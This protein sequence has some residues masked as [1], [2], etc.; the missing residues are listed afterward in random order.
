MRLCDLPQVTAEASA[1]MK[2]QFPPRAPAVVQRPPGYS[3]SHSVCLPTPHLPTCRRESLWPAP[4]RPG[5]AETLFNFHHLE[6]Q[7]GERRDLGG[8]QLALFPWPRASPPLQNPEAPVN[9]GL[10]LPSS[11]SAFLLPPQLWPH[12]LSKFCGPR[13]GQH[14][15]APQT[16][17]SHS[18]VSPWPVF[19]IL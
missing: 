16:H 7:A 5:F 13:L 10:P 14:I 3:P 4:P 12:F 18:Q 6:G 11:N 8:R 17:F 9:T 2:T 19:Y 1:G 15:E